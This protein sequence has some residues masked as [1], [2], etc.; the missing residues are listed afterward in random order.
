M[1]RIPLLILLGLS[2]GTW[3]LL[4]AQ[5]ITWDSDPIDVAPNAYGN[6]GPKL[7]LDAEGNPVVM[8]GH[9][10]TG[11]FIVRQ[12]DGVFGEPQSLTN[13]LDVFISDA[14][15][16]DIAAQ[17]NT[18]GVTFM[19][20]GNWTTGARFTR[21]DDG[22]ATWSVPV[23]MVPEGTNQDHFMPIPAWDD[24]GNP[25]AAVKH[26]NNPVTEGILRSEDGGATWLP[27]VDANLAA[28]TGEV[29]ECCPSRTTY[30]NG[31]YYSLFRNNN[32]NVRDMWLV[33][34]ADGTTWD[35]TLDIDPT[36]W[37]IA[38]CPETGASV[39]WLPDNRL[40]STFM[41]GGA[42]PSRVYVNVSDPENQD[43]GTP[44]LVTETQS[45]PSAE[46]QPDVA[47]SSAFTVLTWEQ[48]D[49]GYEIAVALTTN[50]NLPQGLV[51]QAFT[52]SDDLSG[53]NRHPDVAIHGNV[54]HLIWQNSQ[55][56]TV[57]YLRG[58]I[59]GTESVSTTPKR[60]IASL[61][62]TGP[63]TVQLVHAVPMSSF[64][65]LDAA[66]SL[67]HRGQCDAS[68]TA[69]IPD[70]FTQTPVLFVRTQV[71]DGPRLL[72]LGLAN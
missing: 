39:D 40:V 6:K 70:R 38:A 15:G 34:S 10:N 5:S 36:D 7:V 51:D 71:P 57:K 17:G 43:P 22:G 55:S 19:I 69:T 1:T 61:Q 26:G 68:G 48:N 23:P 13:A 37:W 3:G 18:L 52:V 24:N 56:G 29:C 66:G 25:F 20:A 8:L 42:G 44:L 16:A 58:T 54:V 41:S 72:R 21:S 67:L 65:V 47:S 27:S 45:S 49:G 14:E 11:L 31:R 53:S 60:P 50:D 62:R 30:H 46:N 12:E 28:G 35:Q 4:Q 64:D 2:L 59:D 33:S 63:S 32:E 9:S